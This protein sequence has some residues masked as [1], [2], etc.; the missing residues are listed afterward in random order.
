[1]VA[2]VGQRRKTFDHLEKPIWYFFLSHLRILQLNFNHTSITSVDQLKSPCRRNKILSA[3]QFLLTCTCKDILYVFQ[4]MYVS[5]VA[6]G[7]FFWMIQKLHIFF[8]QRCQYYYISGR[9]VSFTT[10]QL[11]KILPKKMKV[12]RTEIM[13]KL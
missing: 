6:F 10:F 8:L 5:F 9:S 2:M 4:V 12:F 7:N 11:F 3:F 13:F 1:M